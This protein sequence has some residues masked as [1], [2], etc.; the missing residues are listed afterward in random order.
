I[1]LA[2]ASRSPTEGAANGILRALGML[3]M[4]CCLEI[5]RG[6]KAAHFKSIS[7]ATGVAYR[8]MLFFDD[9]ESNVKTVSKL[10]ACCFKVSKDSGLTFVAVRSGFKKYRE[11]CLS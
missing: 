9:D 2:V 4:F 5:R 11:V 6:S 10:G 8:D 7:A 1:R 3:D